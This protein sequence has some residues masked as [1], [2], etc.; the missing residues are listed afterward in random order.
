MPPSTASA[1][2]RASV[3]STSPSSSDAFSARAARTSASSWR[4]RAR[5]RASASS[6]ARPVAAVSASAR[7]SAEL[8]AGELAPLVEDRDRHVAHLAAPADRHEQHGGRAEALDEV[9]AQLAAAG[10][11]DDVQRGVGGHHARRAGRPAVVEHVDVAGVLAALLAHHVRVARRRRPG[12]PRTAAPGR[13][14]APRRARPS[15]P[16]GPPRRRRRRRG[17]GEALQAR[18]D[19]ARR[20]I[21]LDVGGGGSGD[22]V[23]NGAAS[24]GRGVT[25]SIG[26]RGRRS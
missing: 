16:R 20:G 11:V 25:T 5:A 19:R 3:R 8:V 7:A 1:A 9:L 24:L 21:A 26:R 2:S 22:L 17:A 12:R 18:R 23:G 15:A 14:R 4:A 10:G 6:R 13:R